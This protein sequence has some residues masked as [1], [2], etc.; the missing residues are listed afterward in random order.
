MPK[1]INILCK[2]KSWSIVS[3]ALDKSRK[4]QQAYKLLPTL[5]IRESYIKLIAKLVEEFFKNQI[6]YRLKIFFCEKFVQSVGDEFFK[7]FIKLQ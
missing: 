6:D 1:F 7:Y 2:S 5:L 4:I 3:K